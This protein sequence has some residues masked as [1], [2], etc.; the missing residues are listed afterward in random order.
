MSARLTALPL[1]AWALFIAALVVQGRLDLYLHPAFRP[2]TVAMGIIL[3]VLALVLLLAGDRAAA[4]HAQGSE[5]G[6]LLRAAALVLPIA[7]ALV[8]QPQ[9]FS[10]Q[11]VLNRGVAKDPSLFFPGT[12]SPLADDLPLPGTASPGTESDDPGTDADAGAELPEFFQFIEKN[13]QGAWKLELLDLIFA[14]ET[15]PLRRAL[16]RERIELTGQV[17]TRLDGAGENRFSLVR[18]LMV[19]CAADARPVGVWIESPQGA[20]GLQDMDWVKVSGR[21]EFPVIQGRRLPLL[22]AESVTPCP[23]PPDWFLYQ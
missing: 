17:V 22:R 21:P 23:P 10:L 3:A 16:A 8:L 9:R 15:P 13:P 4:G 19:C 1:L 14:A 11:T 12:S 6:G 20:S 7:A 18:L 2:W 5:S